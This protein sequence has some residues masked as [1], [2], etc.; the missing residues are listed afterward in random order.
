MPVSNHGSSSD[1]RRS[2][3]N[4]CAD[5]YHTGR[6]WENSCVK[7]DHR[8]CRTGD[9]EPRIYDCRCWKSG[10]T[11]QWLT[12]HYLVCGGHWLHDLT[13]KGWLSNDLTAKGWLSNDL[14][15]KSWLINDLTA[16]GW[17]TNYYL[18]LARQLLHDVLGTKYRLTNH[19]WSLLSRD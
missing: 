19:L 8:V 17:L 5:T 10:C 12:Y 6:L 4:R 7:T 1:D 2:W 3:E 15:A 9:C 11:I 13:A 16:K 14:T 18:L